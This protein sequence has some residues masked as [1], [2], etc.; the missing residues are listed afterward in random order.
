MRAISD[1]L[2]RVYVNSTVSLLKTVQTNKGIRGRL[3]LVV[4]S[5]SVRLGLRLPWQQGEPPRSPLLH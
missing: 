5:T 4:L 1:L 2:A 3:A